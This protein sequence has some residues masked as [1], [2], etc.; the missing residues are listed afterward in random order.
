MLYSNVFPRCPAQLG[1][2]ITP[3]CLYLVHHPRFSPT[4]SSPVSSGRILHLNLTVSF[5][6]QL[7][8]CHLD[9]RL[10][11]KII[12][13]TLYPGLHIGS[14]RYLPKGLTIPSDTA[15]TVFVP[16]SHGVTRSL[17]FCRNRS[18][19]HVIFFSSFFFFGK[20]LASQ[21]TRLTMLFMTLF[22]SSSK[23]TSEYSIVKINW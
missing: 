10:R 18:H 15:G 7:L 13:C 12:S 19:E 3:P 6:S 5:W 11:R 20:A 23:A 4:I 2:L 8:S 22:Q 21:P 9:S 16:Y 1:Y 14:E 17:L